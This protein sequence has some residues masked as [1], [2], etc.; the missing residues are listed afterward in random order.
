M[1]CTGQL[2]VELRTISGRLLACVQASAEE[3]AGTLQQRIFHTMADL[4]PGEIAGRL[5]LVHGLHALPENSRLGD[6]SVSKCEEGDPSNL[7]LILVCAA[8]SGLACR[9]K[10]LGMADIAESVFQKEHELSARTQPQ[11]AALAA[12]LPDVKRMQV[13]AWL[14]QSCKAVELRSSIFYGAV[15]TLDRYLAA[16]QT[17]Q[18]DLLELA[19]AAVCTEIKLEESGDFFRD[20]WQTI[21]LRLSRGQTPLSDILKAEAKILTRLNFEVGV[22]TT[23]GFLEGLAMRLTRPDGSFEDKQTALR[24]GL[25]RLLLEI[26]LYD[27]RLQYGYLPAI[28]A[29][30]ALGVSLFA[31]GPTQPAENHRFDEC[32]RLQ[33]EHDALLD[34]LS[35][36]CPWTPERETSLQH[37]QQQFLETWKELK[38]RH[39]FL[40]R[41]YANTAQYH[42]HRCAAELRGVKLM[43]AELLDLC[44]HV[45]SRHFSAMHFPART[46]S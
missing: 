14:A 20:E 32:A 13:V 27:V 17:E 44:P 2:R 41:L 31:V 10:D 28:L 42:A 38:L 45:A 29:A 7:S 5:S 33:S 11:A 3:K 46:G 35:S 6:C 9:L 26:A 22:P 30:G 21:L 4:E 25:A 24:V 43:P 37:C 34:D 36:Y 12:A 1:A 18:D 15:L 8:P 19:L 23:L 16:E 40:S 39:G